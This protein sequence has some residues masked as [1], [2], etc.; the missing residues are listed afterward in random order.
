MGQA[1]WALGITGSSRG[2]GPPPTWDAG[3]VPTRGSGLVVWAEPFGQG[4]EWL[5]AAGRRQK[6]SV[7]AC[8][9]WDTPP[10]EGE[11]RVL[12]T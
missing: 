2:G 3:H 5:S 9:V 7:P 4:G 6:L 8:R 11:H 12:G 10:L 1:R